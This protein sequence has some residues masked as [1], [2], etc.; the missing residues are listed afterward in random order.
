MVVA[1]GEIDDAEALMADI[2]TFAARSLAGFKLP[3]SFEFCSSLPYS[4][5]G[6]LLRRELR[7]KG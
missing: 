2:K 3:R 4:P 5:T 7:A 1:T 6:K